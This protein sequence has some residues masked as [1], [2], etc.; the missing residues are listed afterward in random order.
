[1]QTPVLTAVLVLL[2]LLRLCYK[3][4]HYTEAEP[5]LPRMFVWTLE[6]FAFVLDLTPALVYEGVLRVERRVL[7]TK[8]PGSSSKFMNGRLERAMARAR[9]KAKAVATKTTTQGQ[10]KRRTKTSDEL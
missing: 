8:T 1:M 2:L 5:T 10:R 6:L 4:S 9:L 3:L 7:G